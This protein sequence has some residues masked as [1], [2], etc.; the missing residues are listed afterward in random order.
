MNP[1]EL[2]TEATRLNKLVLIGSIHHGPQ[3]G[4]LGKIDNDYYQVVGDMTIK[5][6]TKKVEAALVFVLKMEAFKERQYPSENMH[7]RFLNPEN[8]RSNDAPWVTKNTVTA[9]DQDQKKESNDSIF[10]SPFESMPE[11]LSSASMPSQAPAPAPTVIIK[12]RRMVA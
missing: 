7:K 10:V 9:K 11:R 3:I 5:L 8:K 4:A 1:F 2:K 6:N 12:K